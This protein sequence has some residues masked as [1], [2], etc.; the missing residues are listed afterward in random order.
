MSMTFL[1]LL[2]P[3]CSERGFLGG[4]LLL[5]LLLTVLGSGSGSGSGGSWVLQ[6]WFVVQP[7]GSIPSLPVLVI[8]AYAV[9]PPLWLPLRLISLGGWLPLSRGSI[10]VW[11]SPLPCFVTLW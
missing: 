10:W 6:G 7:L 8:L 9:Q 3:P 4:V 1:L 5:P 11:P 2:L